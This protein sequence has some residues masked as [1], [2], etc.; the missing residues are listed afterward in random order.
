M[1][2]IGLK[3]MLHC[4]CQEYRLFACMFPVTT[5]FT[6]YFSKVQCTYS[7]LLKKKSCCCIVIW[8]QDAFLHNSNSVY[9]F[10]WIKST[11]L[12]CSDFRLVVNKYESCL[13]PWSLNVNFHIFIFSVCFDFHAYCFV[14]SHLRIQYFTL[15]V[16]SS[17]MIH[18]CSATFYLTA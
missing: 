13:E 10:S 18:F 15:I 16:T 11:L 8:F 3:L 6:A 1:L 7:Q 14:S 12:F 4:M 2:G 17:S 5:S 9:A